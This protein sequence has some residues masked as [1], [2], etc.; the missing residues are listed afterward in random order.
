MGSGTTAAACKALGIPFVGVERIESF[1]EL[2]VRR[3][4]QEI[5]QFNET[6]PR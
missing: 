2:A 3:L 1:C 6:V 4:D 5:L